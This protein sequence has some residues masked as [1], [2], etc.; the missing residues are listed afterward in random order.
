MQPTADRTFW[1]G[2]R[3]RE[4]LK[5]PKGLRIIEEPDPDP[6]RVIGAAYELSVGSEYYI[7]SPSEGWSGTPAKKLGYKECVAI[8]PGQF[9]LLI[10]REMVRMPKKSLGFFSVKSNLKWQGL[11]NVSGFHVD[12]GYCGRLLVA[13]Y[14]AG[15]QQIQLR[16]GDAAFPLWIAD[17]DEL[18]DPAD[19]RSD[20]EPIENLPIRVLNKIPGS[21]ASPAALDKRLSTL[22]LHFSIAKWVLAAVVTAWITGIFEK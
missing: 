8:P 19:A 1:S 15:P 9:A 4:N 14:N 3:I 6:K 10:T 7:S 22:E 20:D 18:A 11:V 5:E 12:P 17:L 16:Q 2:A 21:S 13:V